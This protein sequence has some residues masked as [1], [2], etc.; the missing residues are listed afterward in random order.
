[1]KVIH[2]SM[3]LLFIIM[4]AGYAQTLAD[5]C[6]CN[7]GNLGSIVICVND[8]SY[9]VQLRGCMKQPGIYPDT[10]PS[11][12]DSAFSQNLYTSITSVCF[13]SIR[14][15]VL[16]AQKIFNAVVCALDPCLYPANF[17]INIPPNTIYCWTVVT[18]KCVFI[19][20][21][22][23]CVYKCGTGCCI[24]ET[25]WFRDEEGD[26]RMRASWS[27]KVEPVNC[28]G[29]FGCFQIDCPQRDTSC[30]AIN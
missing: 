28:A 1:M 8:T 29:P 18:P 19:N 26:C 6:G 23:G 25:R 22:L 13:G 4:K 5:K 15:A 9:Q 14:P 20:D 17:G 11:L 30:C 2:L 27:C 12:C 3:L 21:A 16:D 24:T 10:L 7:P